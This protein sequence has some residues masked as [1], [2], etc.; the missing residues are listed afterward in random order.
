MLRT[1]EVRAF[2]VAL[3]FFGLGIS[4]GLATT[5]AAVWI[6]PLDALWANPNAWTSSPYAPNNGLPTAPDTWDVTIDVNSLLA[7]PYT[8]TISSSVTVDNLSLD[9]RDAVLSVQLS[10]LTVDQQLTLTRGELA[11]NGSLLTLQNLDLDAPVGTMRARVEASQLDLLGAALL[12]QG[13]F[14]LATSTVSGG[15]WTLLPQASFVL[16]GSTI[17]GGTWTIASGVLAPTNDPANTLDGATIVGEIDMTQF[18]NAQLHVQ[19]GSTLNARLG[20][21]ADLIFDEDTTRTNEIISID[22][23]GPNFEGI[24]APDGVTLTL[25]P[26]TQVNLIGYGASLGLSSSGTIINQGLVAFT[27]ESPYDWLGIWPDTFSNM[28]EI[29]MDNAM[30]ANVGHVLRP[31]ARWTNEASG[32]IFGDASHVDFYGNGLNFG[33]FRFLNG[34][35][36]EVHGSWD[37]DGTVELT[38]SSLILLGD[39]RGE[40]VGRVL[41]SGVSSVAFG[42]RLDNHGNTLPVIPGASYRLEGGTIFGGIVNTSASLPLEF[43]YETVSTL[44][45]ALVNGD[46]HVGEVLSQLELV[47]G[48]TFTGNADLGA[49]ATLVFNQTHTLNGA[50]VSVGSV[51]LVNARFGVGGSNTLTIGTGTLLELL[52]DGSQLTSDLLVPGIGVIVNNGAITAGGVDYGAF[53]IDP[54]NFINTGTLTIRP[55]FASSLSIGRTGSSWENTTS[56][57]IFV[58]GQSLF[59]DGEGL[60]RGIV[61]ADGGTVRFGGDWLNLGT[62]RLMDDAHLILDGSFTTEEMGTIQADSTATTSIAGSL[63]NTGSQLLLDDIGRL[64]GDGGTIVGG[65]VVQG[66]APAMSGSLLILDGV[67]V[68]GDLD[69]TERNAVMELRNG[70]TF[71]GPATI[72]RF[73]RLEIDSTSTLD[74]VLIDINGGGGRLE[75]GDG[76]ELTLGQN[77]V[78]NLRS[79]RAGIGNVRIPQLG[80]NIVNQ[81][82][83]HAMSSIEFQ[84]SPTFFENQGVVLADSF[85]DLTVGAQGT[86]WINAPSGLIRVDNASLSLEGSYANHGRIEMQDARIFAAVLTNESDGLLRLDGRVVG[87]TVN[88]G[89]LEV[90]PGGIFDLLEIDSDLNLQPGSRL[91]LDT[92]ESTADMI[93]VGGIATVDGELSIRAWT[94]PADPADVLVLATASTP[95]QGS[96]ANILSGDRLETVIGESS[97]Q[98][99]YGVAPYENQIVATNFVPEADGNW[100]AL[101]TVAAIYLRLGAIGR[102]PQSC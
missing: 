91:V 97:F 83:I 76:Q 19:N 94:P 86:S 22:G 8:V 52:G 101:L 74:G 12:T 58:D 87:S 82:L 75:V 55:E 36:I 7:V 50:T 77:T 85:A 80:G 40:D 25:A 72:G 90:G 3:A 92:G 73:A 28:G 41:A 5:M 33:T 15:D 11:I 43:G 63:D 26:T 38:D 66:S 96:F 59:M 10:D 21:E 62:I 67:T 93:D 79:R 48:A 98:V 95:I 4:P 23:S 27:G 16:D 68:S 9:S 45:G 102:T 2:L 35:E 46:L 57:S 17:S 64:A 20:E 24:V 88:D 99:I 61:T 78:V 54:D 56:G 34:S 69:L 14:T 32:L 84:I 47:N 29:H 6:S 1:I 60:N 100:I 89:T 70:T 49:A 30:F 65:E 13:E 53:T 39:L 18:Y 71:E 42:G 81:G 44:D 37:N 51:G 31:F